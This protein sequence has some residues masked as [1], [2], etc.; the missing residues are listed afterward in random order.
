MK[1]IFGKKRNKLH[2]IIRNGKESSKTIYEELDKKSKYEILEDKLQDLVDDLK[3][4]GSDYMQGM[5]IDI[6]DEIVKVVTDTKTQMNLKENT[7]LGLEEFID[8]NIP[9]DVIWKDKMIELVT[10]AYELG[11]TNWEDEYFSLSS[12]DR[13]E[14]IHRRLNV[15]I[16]KNRER[17]G[18][19]KDE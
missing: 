4:L 15:E 7:Y 1:N 8:N 18:L 16:L 6:L 12:K 17:L 19:D 11:S 2:F 10:K 3:D 5:Y 14:V 13:I 9:T